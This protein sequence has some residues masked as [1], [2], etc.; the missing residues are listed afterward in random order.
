[1]LITLRR[2]WEATRSSFCFVPAEIAL[3]AVALATVLIAV[4]ATVELDFVERWPLLFGA[5]A[6][7][8]RGL[9]TAVASS[10]FCG[11]SAAGTKGRSSLR[12]QCWPA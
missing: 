12:W 1:M 5:G 8:S 4:D 7:G 3:G 2:W 10:W 11:P 9:L 6:A